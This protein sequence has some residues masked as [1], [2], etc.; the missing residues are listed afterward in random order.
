MTSSNSSSHQWFRESLSS[1]RVSPISANSSDQWFRWLPIDLLIQA[2]QYS[3][4][5]TG[6]MYK[7]C[8]LLQPPRNPPPAASTVVSSIPMCLLYICHTNKNNI[9]SNKNTK[10]L[11]VNAIV[12]SFK[13][14]Q[15]NKHRTETDS[16]PLFLSPS[17][18]SNKNHLSCPNCCTFSS[19][20]K[21]IHPKQ[22]HGEQWNR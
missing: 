10:D 17:I 6:E 19:Q 11:T 7:T 13:Q 12:N 3:Y 20:P 21:K 16:Y 22:Q 4:T 5:V 15:T 18:F 8:P 14:K 1:G 9:Y 2:A